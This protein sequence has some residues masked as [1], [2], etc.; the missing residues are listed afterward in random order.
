V[1]KISS[2]G[3][4]SSGFSNGLVD[5]QITLQGVDLIGNFS[6]DQQ[7]IADLLSKKKLIID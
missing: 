5:Q 2:T 4:F 6:A 3:G 1:V 7:V